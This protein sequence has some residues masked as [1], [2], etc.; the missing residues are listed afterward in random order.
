MTRSI[1]TIA[2]GYLAASALTPA[3]QAQRVDARVGGVAAHPAPASRPY[4]APVNP[5]LNLPPVTSAPRARIGADGQIA[6][7]TRATGAGANPPRRTREPQLMQELAP[8]TPTVSTPATRAA[9]PETKAGS[10]IKATTWR[11]APR[12]RRG[13]RR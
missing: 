4:S 2:T 1:L 12:R 7:D 6:A 8:E 11:K 10:P 3:A 9:A 13:H 5:T